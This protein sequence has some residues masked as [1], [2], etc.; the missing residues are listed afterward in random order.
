MEELSQTLECQDVRVFKEPLH[1]NEV[2]DD[3]LDLTQSLKENEKINTEY[4]PQ[5]LG[6][7]FYEQYQLEKAIF[8]FPNRLP[9]LK[10]ASMAKDLV[11]GTDEDM[12]LNDDF[13]KPSQSYVLPTY[14]IHEQVEK[15]Y[16]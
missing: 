3:Y 8:S 9:G 2:T 13:D 11:M 14:S 12:T 1:K 6:P 4:F 5:Q 7:S 10:T 16:F 15:A